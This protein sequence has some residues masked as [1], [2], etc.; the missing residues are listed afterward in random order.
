MVG[1]D[2]VGVAPSSAGVGHDLDRLAPVAPLAVG[3][4]V[5]PEVG[6]GD[7]DGERPGQSRLDLALVLPQ[8]GL[9]EGQVE[10]AVGLRLGGERPEL[11]VVARQDLAVVADPLEAVLGQAPAPITGPRPEPDVVL[12][13]PR[14]MDPV[15]A[16]G[17]RRHHHEVDLRPAQEP[18]GR[19]VAAPADHGIDDA[20]PREAVHQDGGIGR[21][22]QEVEVA[23]RLLLPAERAR[24]LD[25]RHPRDRR[26]A[27]AEGE[28]VLLG[29]VEEQARGPRE[30]PLDPL[31][32]QLLRPLREPA[33]RAN[34][35]CP[36]RDFQIAERQDAELVVELLDRLRPE[37]RD[38]EDLD[39]ARR[40]LF[41]E[42]LEIGHPARR[43]ELGDLVGDRLADARDLRRRPVPEGDDEVDRAPTDGIGR[44]V[45]GDRLEGEL[46][47]DLEDVADLVEDSGEVTVG[48]VGGLVGEHVGG[49]LV[50]VG[51]VG[52]GLVER[53]GGHRCDG[54][55]TSRHGR[56]NGR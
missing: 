43:D 33:D 28:D 50:V 30:E 12:L 39:E 31:E 38:L 22:G 18:D 25:G 54:T 13:A 10:E 49:R 9:D 32:D 4:A 40:H 6:L 47:L 36:R 42:P 44:P 55:G 23:D 26:E 27:R 15:G 5:A 45:V 21:L 7:E 8:L 3:V 41:A 24:R 2:L 51:G 34:A 19:L 11:R 35:A 20:E 17:T 1:Q 37:A 14:E 16:R 52:E 53:V 29:A 56:P 48:Q 46:A